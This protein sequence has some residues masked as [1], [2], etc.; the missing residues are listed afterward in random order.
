MDV[1]DMPDRQAAQ[2]G[3]RHNGGRPE[4]AVHKVGLQAPDRHAQVA[5]AM[6]EHL[7]LAIRTTIVEGEGFA[8]CRLGVPWRRRGPENAEQGFIPV[9][10]AQ[11]LND[12]ESHSF[13]AAENPVPS[14]SGNDVQDFSFFDHDPAPG[15][16][17]FV[18]EATRKR[19][20]PRFELNVSSHFSAA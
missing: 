8:D 15:F 10:R 12:I 6:Q 14:E 4:M 2:R 7:N 16:R 3:R 20:A 1:N 11:M 19:P 9:A 5:R 18:A 17:F 13:G